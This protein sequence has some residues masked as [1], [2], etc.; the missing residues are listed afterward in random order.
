MMQNNESNNKFSRFWKTK[1]YYMLLIACLAAV[2]V[3]GYLFVSGALE[4]QAALDESL[5]VPEQAETAQLP[6]E[7]TMETAEE[8]PMESSA[9][10]A[11]TPVEET[12][13]VQ[14]V[15]EE[16]VLPVSGSVLQDYAMEQLAYNPTTQDWRVHR[17]VDLAA[18]MGQTVKAARGGTVT[19]VY[20][21]AYLGHTVVVQHNGG[22][23]SHYCNLAPEM[24]VSA[25][26]TV[27]TGQPLGAIGGTALIEVAQEPHL[28]FEVYHNGEPVDPA[29]FLY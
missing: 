9:A 16:T 18:P 29:G 13:Q 1:G 23:T 4:E 14:P 6:E 7:P 8:V 17:G 20:E 5:S 11:G 22:Y 2:G 15:F 27:T 21:D 3:S 12:P 26:D 28:H 10:S 25:G 19:A 24:T